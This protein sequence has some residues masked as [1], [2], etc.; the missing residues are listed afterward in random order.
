[1]NKNK[2]MEGQPQ[3]FKPTMD[4]DEVYRVL[5]PFWGH[6]KKV[7]A[8]CPCGALGRIKRE[9]KRLEGFKGDNQ[10]QE[11]IQQR[12]EALRTLAI[13]GDITHE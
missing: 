5:G 9:I 2:E 11:R 3:L 10:D 13:I 8:G 1:M 4:L 12:I 6:I 7:R